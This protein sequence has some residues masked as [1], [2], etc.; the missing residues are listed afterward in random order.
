MIDAFIKINHVIALM[1]CNDNGILMK[2]KQLK[3]ELIL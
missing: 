3:C 2:R 1:T